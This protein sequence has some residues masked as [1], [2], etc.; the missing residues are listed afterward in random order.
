M[1]QVWFSVSKLPLLTSEEWATA[2]NYTANFFKIGNE[3]EERQLYRVMTKDFTT[4]Q[5]SLE[6]LGKTIII[7][8]AMNQD[9][10]QVIGFVRNE[11]EFLKYMQPVL[12]DDV[13]VATADNTSAGWASFFEVIE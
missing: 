8:D 9:G 1:Y 6:T 5:T 2:G 12:I 13:E 11:T 7:C 4:L 10:S 3:V